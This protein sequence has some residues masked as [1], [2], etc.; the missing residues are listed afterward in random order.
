M[1]EYAPKTAGLH[2]V[3]AIVCEEVI[4]DS[5]FDSVL[6]DCMSFLQLN[7]SND[8]NTMAPE[9]YINFFM[10][11]KFHVS[12]VKLLQVGSCIYDHG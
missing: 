7:S 10:I 3:L 12:S 4:M 1:Y 5:V 6:A 2:S 11:R 8:A 9:V